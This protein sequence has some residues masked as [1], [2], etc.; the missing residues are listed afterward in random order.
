MERHSENLASGRSGYA[1]YNEG[2]AQ[3]V[4]IFDAIKQGLR[5]YKNVFALF[6]FKRKKEDIATAESPQ[7]EEHIEMSQLM[8][9]DDFQGTLKRAPAKG[10]DFAAQQL[11]NPTWCDECGDFI[12]GVY[13][14]CLKCNSKY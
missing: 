1:D 14:Q 12:W 2:P 11:S 10:H 9:G 8:T 5:N 3:E 13:K 7:V 6:P 4:D